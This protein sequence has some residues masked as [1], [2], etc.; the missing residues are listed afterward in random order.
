MRVAA[1][2]M[3]R[4]DVRAIGP[5]I[6]AIDR[7]DRHQELARGTAKKWPTAETDQLAL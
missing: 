6:K 2:K 4:G 5:F 7:P 3:I 1:E